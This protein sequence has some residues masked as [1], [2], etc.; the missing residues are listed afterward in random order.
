MIVDV[1]ASDKCSTALDLTSDGFKVDS[2]LSLM[3]E[4]ILFFA[5]T[6]PIPQDLTGTGNRK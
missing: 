1:S 6:L 5:M 3:L 4:Y 2:P